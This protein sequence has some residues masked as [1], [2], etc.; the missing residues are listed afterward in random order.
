MEA[1]A[2]ESYTKMTGNIVIESGLIIK[3]NQSWL[4]SSPDGLIKDQKV[5]LVIKCP[6]SCGNATISVD[7]VKDSKLIQTHPYFTQVQLQMYTSNS[8]VCHFFVFS[9]KNH[10]LINVPRDDEFL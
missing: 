4:C 3:A 5:C 2:R 1:T 10:I 7:Y 8:D 9:Q 6:S